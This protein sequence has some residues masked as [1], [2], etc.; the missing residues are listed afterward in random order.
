M[1]TDQSTATPSTV[2]A[3]AR[4]RE[5]A[6]KR[7]KKRRDFYAHLLVYVLVNAMLVIIWATTTP[8]GFFWPAFPMAAWG[9]GVGMN[10]WDVFRDDEFRETQIQREMDR[11]QRDA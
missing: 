3:E 2:S 4:L 10:A 9:I 8:G 6:I 11:I 5:R 1:T 7:L